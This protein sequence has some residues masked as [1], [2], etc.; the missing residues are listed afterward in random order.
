MIAVL[1]VGALQEKAMRDA[2]DR[3]VFRSVLPLTLVFDH[4][5]VDGAYAGR[6]LEALKDMIEKDTGRVF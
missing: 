1:C 3:L 4:R 2:G 6:F 5:P